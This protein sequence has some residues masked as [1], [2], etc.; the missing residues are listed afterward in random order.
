MA[1][2]MATELRVMA[3]ELR[4]VTL[5]KPPI[6]IMPILRVVITRAAALQIKVP[7]ASKTPSTAPPTRVP[8]KG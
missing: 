3:T 4:V 1:T 8:T 6:L 7:R 5:P 2:V